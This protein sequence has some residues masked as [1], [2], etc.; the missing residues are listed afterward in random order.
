MMSSAESEIVGG[1][2]VTVDDVLIVVLLV[3]GDVVLGEEVVVVLGDDVVVALE[4]SVSAPVSSSSPT[5]TFGPQAAVASGSTHPSQASF[6]VM[7][8]SPGFASGAPRGHDRPVNGNGA[9]PNAKAWSIVGLCLLAGCS[10]EGSEITED[11]RALPDAAYCDPVREWDEAHAEAEATVR[12]RIDA[13]RG[14]GADCGTRGKLGPAPA[15]QELGTLRCAARVHA[16]DMATREFIDHENPDEELVADRVGHAGGS[17]LDV[18]E[19]IAAGD[20]EPERVVDE[21][22]MPTPG[23]CATL[24]GDAF[25]SIG[26][27][28]L[29][30]TEDPY[31]GF[32]TVVVA[33]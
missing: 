21:V 7:T 1:A 20:I 29:G 4:T 13:W 24:M 12:A 5:A 6:M 22:W 15:L 11:L 27:G 8:I 19:A 3:L 32:W 23:S 25:T 33:R 17:F 31:G 28:Y 18:A 30:D 14:S 26:I 16:L 2:V 10:D 9:R